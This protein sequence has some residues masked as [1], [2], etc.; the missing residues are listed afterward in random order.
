MK[1][2]YNISTLNVPQTINFNGFRA[3]SAAAPGAIRG[4]NTSWFAVKGFTTANAVNNFD[5][6]TTNNSPKLKLG[7]STG[8]NG[9]AGAPSASGF[10]SFKTNP[11]DTNDRALGFQP[12]GGD[13]TPGFIYF[14]VK[15]ATA[16]TINNLFFSFTLEV[17]NDQ[18]R[19][20]NV[21]LY[22]GTDT[23][24]ANMTLAN[25]YLS[26]V[27]AD[28]IIVWADT[29][30]VANVVGLSLAPN[31]DYFFLIK[32]DDVSGAGSRDEFAINDLTILATGAAPSVTINANFT[33]SSTTICKGSTVA[34]TNTTTTVPA[35]TPLIYFW[36]FK[37]GDI[38]SVASPSH[39]F[40]S[41]GT[42]NVTL[43]AV[44][45]ISFALDSQI[46]AIQVGAIPNA[47]FTFS[48]IGG[49]YTFAAPA[50]SLSNLTYAWT[51][52]GV[53]V[54]SSQPTYNNTFTANGL[55][56][57]CLK[58]TNPI[59]GC[60]DSICKSVNVV[61]P[62]VN[63]L[64]VNI[65]LSD[66]V[67]CVGDSVALTTLSVIGG[68]APLTYAWFLNGNAIPAPTVGLYNQVNNPGL[69]TLKLIVT[70]S[71]N[72]TKTDSVNLLVRPLPNANFTAIV[73]ASNSAQYIV[74]ITSVSALV[75]YALF[76]N[77]TPTPL[78]GPGPY[79]I[80]F[81]STGSYSVCLK[82]NNLATTCIDSVCQTLNVT[83]GLDKI[84]KKAD[85]KLYPNPA[86]D[87]ISIDNVKE[88]VSLKVF[89]AIGQ[90]VKEET[91]TTNTKFNIKDLQAGIYFV[92]IKSNTT[93]KTMRLVIQ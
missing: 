32:T 88:K 6:G 11:L 75:N 17:R 29:Q 57:V 31:S 52:N 5:F 92:S 2:Q 91:L 39:Q 73:S 82:A 33:A 58:I 69:R 56:T 50:T 26:P 66:S 25:T 21:Q 15:N 28:P 59:G 41:A 68:T 27:A 3:D 19:S 20:N 18:G 93:S 64:N 61:L 7:T 90:L 37:D 23:I 89:N 60:K 87:F 80:S 45:T 36:D 74:S 34:F 65:A 53:A 54:G 76:V 47:N 24:P 30:M 14:K 84:A 77:G 40:D 13:L 46:V 86:H 63:T 71:N 83:V 67:V 12:T 42:Y 85:I 22:Y 70:D 51:L 72:F 35:N 49:A 55:N 44:D 79:L 16:Q 62:A 9:G 48:N 38:D 1:A 43:Y 8:G 4:I 81:P 10:Y 78:V